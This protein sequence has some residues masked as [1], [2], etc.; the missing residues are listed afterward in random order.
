MGKYGNR[1]DQDSNADNNPA[2]ALPAGA[3]TDAGQELE[4]D[5]DNLEEISAMLSQFGIDLD[6]LNADTEDDEDD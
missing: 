2:P 4:L 3:D 6:A 5:V 1:F